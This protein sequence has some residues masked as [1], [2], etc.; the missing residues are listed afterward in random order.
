M[1]KSGDSDLILEERVEAPKFLGLTFGV[2]RKVT[3]HEFGLM[4]AK[5]KSTIRKSKPN[6]RVSESSRLG[7]EGLDS[8]HL[9]QKRWEK[10][11]TT[12]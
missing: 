10:P 2:P 1:A 9:I 3:A 7:K 12:H 5:R 6:L 4:T 8:N 11:K